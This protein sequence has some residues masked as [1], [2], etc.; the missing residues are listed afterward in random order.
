MSLVLKSVDEYLNKFEKKQEKPKIKSEPKKSL[1]TTITS[2]KFKGKKLALPSLKTTRSTK[3]I[4][5]QSFFNTT[6]YE[7][8]DALFIEGFG[9]SALMACEAVSNG[10]KKALAIEIDKAAYK[11]ASKNCAALEG[12]AA[13]VI[14]G[15]S[16]ELL[17]EVILGADI[18]VIL[19]LDPPFDIRGG[20]E[21]VYD[22][23]FKLLN[24]VP[25]KR[26]KIVCFE[27]SSAVAM[28]EQVGD[29]NKIKS[30]KFGSTSLTY[31]S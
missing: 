2:G 11:L 4:V 22:R 20:F 6:R 26:V 15:D 12:C 10:A 14:L 19:Y 13:S 29:F 8:D 7:L 31:Y 3:S 1:F 24:D 28:P 17:M 18:P 16:F 21:R 23:L 9:G 25:R 30:K 27:H 5:R